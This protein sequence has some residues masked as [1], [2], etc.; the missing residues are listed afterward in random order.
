[1]CVSEYMNIAMLGGAGNQVC[2]GEHWDFAMLGRREIKSVLEQV[3][4]AMLGMR[5]IRSVLEHTDFAMLGRQEITSVLEQ[6]NFAELKRR[7]T[8]SRGGLGR[9]SLARPDHLSGKRPNA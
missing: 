7:R 5:E 8:F 4:F 6:L 9:R 2:F 3:N 1:M